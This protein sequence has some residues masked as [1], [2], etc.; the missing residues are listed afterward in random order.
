MVLFLDNNMQK[1]DI[2]PLSY[3]THKDQL[4]MH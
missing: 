1:G 2:W 4:K 3:S